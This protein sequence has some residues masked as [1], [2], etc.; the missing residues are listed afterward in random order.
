MEVDVRLT[1]SADQPWGFRLIGGVDF[2][3]PLTVVKVIPNSPADQAGLQNGDTVYRINDV[4]CSSVTHDDSK[5]ILAAVG[6]SLTLG[7]VRG[8]YDPVLDDYEPLYEPIDQPDSDQPSQPTEV[9]HLENPEKTPNFDIPPGFNLP[10][11]VSNPDINLV[12]KKPEFIDAQKFELYIPEV[13]GNPDLINDQSFVGSRSLTASPFV[14]QTKPYRPFSTEPLVNVPPLEDPI[15]LNPDYQDVFGR[16]TSEEFLPATRFKLPISEQYD[17]DGT[18]QK[19]KLMKDQKD[20]KTT[21]QFKEETS[22]KKE[23]SEMKGEVISKSEVKFME[24]MKKDIDLEKIEST[25]CSIVDESIEKALTVA[26]QIKQEM[27]VELSE[28]SLSEVSELKSH[29]ESTIVAESKTESIEKSEKL[30]AAT[31]TKMSKVESEIS[32]V[33]SKQITVK[34]AAELVE[35]I[36]KTTEEIIKQDERKSESIITNETD[37]KKQESVEERKISEAST[38]DVETSEVKAST[39]KEEKREVV[40]ESETRDVQRKISVQDTKSKV[41]QRDLEEKV[42]RTQAAVKEESITGTRYSTSKLLAEQRAY[43]LGLQTIPNLKGTAHSSYHYNLLL[44]TFFIHL[45]DVMVAL[46]RFILAEP[47]LSPTVERETVKATESTERQEIK[48]DVVTKS[49]QETVAVDQQEKVKK[50]KEKV[51][52]ARVTEQEKIDKELEEIEERK[53]QQ[54]QKAVTKDKQKVVEKE[55][56]VERQVVKQKCQADVDDVRRVVELEERRNLSGSRMAQLTEKKPG[57]L[58]EKMEAVITEFESKSSGVDVAAVRERRSRSRNEVEAPVEFSEYDTRSQETTELT[59]TTTSAM[60]SS[61][62]E[63][64]RKKTE[65]KHVTEEYITGQATEGKNTYVAIVQAHVYTNEDAIF[66]EHIDISK[67]ASI[68]EEVVTQKAIEAKAEK[69]LEISAAKKEEKTQV[70]EKAKE[71]VAESK[72]VKM[73]P[74]AVQEKKVE[75]VQEVVVKKVEPV[76]EIKE[77]KSVVQDYKVAEVKDSMAVAETKKVIKHKEEAIATKEENVSVAKESISSLKEESVAIKKDIKEQHVAKEEISTVKEESLASKEESVTI[78]EQ[79]VS[80][81]ET[82]TTKFIAEEKVA[83]V[84]QEVKAVDSVKEEAVSIKSET[85]ASKFVAEEKVTAVKEEIKA[86]ESVKEESVTVKA[87]T[88]AL[89]QVEAVKA[90]VSVVKAQAIAVKEQ[91]QTAVIEQVI[92]EKEKIKQEPVAV[93]QVIDKVEK[94]ESAALKITKEQAIEQAKTTVELDEEISVSM[95]KLEIN[96]FESKSRVEESFKSQHIEQESTFAAKSFEARDTQKLSLRTDLAQKIESQVSVQSE[97]NNVEPTTPIVP[98]TPLTDEYVFKLVIPLPKREGDPIPRDCTPSDDD[99]D[100]DIVKRGLVPHI[101][102]EIQDRVLYDPPLPTPPTSPRTP[103][104]PTSPKSPTYTKPALNGGEASLGFPKPR[105]VYFRPGLRGG[106]PPKTLRR[107]RYIKPGLCGGADRELTQEEILEIERKSS[108]L[109]SAIDETIKSI[110]EYKE[111]VGME[112]GVK[113]E[114]SDNGVIYNGY[115]KIVETKTYDTTTKSNTFEEIQTNSVEIREITNGSDSKIEFK[116]TKSIELTESKP[117]EIES[118]G[119]V[120]LN[121]SKDDSESQ[122]IITEVDDVEMKVDTHTSGMVVGEETIVI[123]EKKIEEQIIKEEK[124]QIPEQIIPNDKPPVE[125]KLVKEEKTKPVQE[126]VIREEMKPVKEMVV[127]E[128][129]RDPM[130]GYKPVHFDPEELLNAQRDRRMLYA[131]VPQMT[132]SQER[133]L[134]KTPSGEIIGTRK[135]IVDG[136]E[137]AIVD[138]DVAKEMGKPGITEEKIAELI[139]GEAEM[140]R[141]AHVMG[142]DFK[143]IKPTIETLKDSEVLKALNEEMLKAYEEKKKEEKKWTTF[144]Q[145]PKRPVPKAKYGY[146]GNLDIEEE[147]LE[148]YKV[149]IVKQPKP[150]VAPDYKPKNFNTGLLPWEERALREPT[151]P[152]VEP[153]EPILIPEEAPEILEAVDPLPESEVPDLEDSGIPLPPPP[154]KEPTPPPE[155]A[156]EEEQPE[157]LDIEAVIEETEKIVEEN[158]AEEMERGNIAEQIMQSVQNMVDPN[159]PLDEQLAQMRAQLAALAQLPGVIQQSLE[160]VTRQLSQLSSLETS[161]LQIQDRKVSQSAAGQESE[162]TQNGTCTIEEIE[163]TQAEPQSPQA[164]TQALQIVTQDPQADAQTHQAVKPEVLAA[165]TKPTISPEEIEQMKREEEAMLEE[166]RK[167]E[168]QKK[169]LME[170][171]RLEHES[172][173]VKQRPTPRVGKPKPVFG[174]AVPQERPLVLPGGRKWRKPKDAF[175]EQLFAE[176]FAAQTEVIA[177][178]AEGF[179]YESVLLPYDPRINFMKY[180]KPPV[181]LDHLK[182]SDVYKMIHNME[183]TPAKRVEMLTPVMAEVDYRELEVLVDF[184]EHPDE[185]LVEKTLNC[186]KSQDQ[187]EDVQFKNGAIVMETTL[188]S[189][190]VL[191]IVTRS[192]GKRAVLQGFGENQSAVAMIASHSCCNGR[193]MGVIRFQQCPEGPLVADGTIDGLDPGEHGLHVRNSGDLSMGCLSLGDHYNPHGSPSHG[194]PNDPKECRH[195]G[196]L[197]NVVADET[198]RACFRIMDCVLNVQDIVGRSVAVTE[199]CDDLGRGSDPRSKVDGNSGKP[200]GC[201]IIARSA[202]VFQNPKRVCL[203]DGVVVWDEKDRPLAGKGRRQEKPATC[204]CKHDEKEEVKTMSAGPGGDDG[205]KNIKYCKM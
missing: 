50:E 95:K 116:E 171:A 9:S 57:E 201:G 37:D 128:E 106:A 100:P 88:A 11:F 90:E 191:D 178:K 103:G 44:K 51:A 56:V 54:T 113:A 110:E 22:V 52:V 173:Q 157:E 125:E 117:S 108:L 29:K 59:T 122:P 49:V 124:V 34:E 96:E 14:G 12:G 196:D 43:A 120:Q 1:R 170:Q 92:L 134:Y 105:P 84:K 184:G 198:G 183:Q 131:Q 112:N 118:N 203:C 2:S 160:L 62:M 21:V 98:P 17:P 148:P 159:A 63:S 8:L 6:D 81:A 129:K 187:V 205:K 130:E 136:L 89:K 147:K 146:A 168:K 32:K 45:T 182:D 25:A 190:V 135:G 200:V 27:D 104:T 82:A 175:N 47:V 80:V 19:M 83:A 186:L 97:Q 180:E 33:E 79:S 161:Q 199:R 66:D 192:S 114:N 154:A 71:I 140:L 181:S 150:K 64:M 86:V 204:C 38:V 126:M 28:S 48:R 76:A 13:L 185:K 7:V 107:P 153:E 41:D 72:P 132:A 3:M 16:I 156:T 46:S 74:I 121:G 144:L 10:T 166:Q 24:Q 158:L 141:E 139:S 111:E 68:A 31:E 138:P 164:D 99:E 197:G 36:D 30:E 75:K 94:D 15:I 85:A 78:K 143:K 176:T 179:S 60:S 67:T 42:T 77:A 91:E 119:N 58:M 155:E 174:P 87:E 149:K 142:V 70:V 93:K 151:P 145:K 202:G 73:E 39:K 169:E 167:M 133:D 152:P 23:I 127:E 115:A 26:E 162:V 102:A 165:E 195:A 61:Y 20:I 172:R 109:A 194:G 35:L 53:F 123:E 65:S 163:S 55:K 189:T 188:P 69:S 18:K 177:G 101:E 40:E 5:E 137:E 4:D 193:V